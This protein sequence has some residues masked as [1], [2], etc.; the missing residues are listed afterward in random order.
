MIENIDIHDQIEVL[1]VIIDL[2]NQNGWF[3]VCFYFFVD[4]LIFYVLFLDDNLGLLVDSK[5]LQSIGQ[6]L[7]GR[8]SSD[9][10]E[11]ERANQT[12]KLLL[13]VSK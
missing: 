7:A 6:F 12:Q 3:V 9:E 2:A 10:L 5:K 13:L 4:L 1:K 8:S 11:I